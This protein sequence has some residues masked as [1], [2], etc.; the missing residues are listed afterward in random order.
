MHVQV[1]RYEFLDRATLPICTVGQ[2]LIAYVECN[3][4]GF[5]L[6]Y[7]NSPF[8]YPV[9]ILLKVAWSFIE[10]IVGS[11]CVANIAV[12][13]AKVAVVVLSDVGRSLV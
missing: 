1:F 7:F 10:V 2:V 12:S 6:I 11:S 5:T 13:S 9:V 3:T 8:L 4:R